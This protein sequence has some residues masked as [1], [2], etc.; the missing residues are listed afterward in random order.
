MFF[1][2]VRRFF[3]NLLFVNLAVTALLYS[4]A[5]NAA[6]VQVSPLISYDQYRSLNVSLQLGYLRDVRQSWVRFESEARDQFPLA[7]ANDRGSHFSQILALFEIPD[8]AATG[9][10]YCPIGGGERELIHFS[11]GKMLCPTKGRPCGSFADGGFQCYPLFA[12]ACVSR[13]PIESLTERCQ[14]AADKE[15]MTV[16]QEDY[17]KIHSDVADLINHCESNSY[18]PNFNDSCNRFRDQIQKLH[19]LASTNSSKKASQ[20]P[21]SSD[22][23]PNESATAPVSVKQIPS[24]VKSDN[25][26][27][28]PQNSRPIS[29]EESEGGDSTVF[30]AKAKRYTESGVGIKILGPCISACVD[31]IANMPIDHVCIGPNAALGF[32]YSTSDEAGLRPN[33]YETEKLVESYPRPLQDFWTQVTLLR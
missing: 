6:A 9:N 26:A 24:P 7:R 13:S 4:A 8:A 1:S 15:P 14:G 21:T 18:G 31:M 29:D 20:P 3:A 12:N 19:E 30:L 27:C 32:H 10:S 23:R 28:F 25:H 5:S 2:L 33:Y 17:E 16:T 11:D 22:S